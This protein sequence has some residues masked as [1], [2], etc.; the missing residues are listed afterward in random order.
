MLTNHYVEDAVGKFRFDY[1][2][3]FLRWALSP[4][5]FIPEWIVGVRG[6]G[7]LTAFISAIPVT[8]SV[9]GQHV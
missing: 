9:N 7:K 4:P 6:A 1:S 2:I 5:G 8:M 3:D